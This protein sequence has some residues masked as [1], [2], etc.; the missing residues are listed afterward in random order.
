MEAALLPVQGEQ[1]RALLKALADPLRLELIKALG[2][3][4]R[5]VR[6]LTAELGLARSKLSFP[7]K[8][9]R[10]AGL[11]DRRQQGRWL[12]E[13]LCPVAL[14]A[15]Q[16]GPVGLASRCTGPALSLSRC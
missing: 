11:I 15:L 3:G 5:C 7:L 10:E 14:T 9:L 1:A 12:F 6:E 8:L 2:E 4:E 13:R 16:Q